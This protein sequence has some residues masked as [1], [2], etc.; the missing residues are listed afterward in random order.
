[1]RVSYSE[2]KTD[3][4]DRIPKRIHTVEQICSR[5]TGV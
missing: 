4:S 1:M 3:E 2:A 5:D